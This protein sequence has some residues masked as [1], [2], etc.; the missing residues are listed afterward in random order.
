[1]QLNYSSTPMSA[2]TETFAGQMR[3]ADVAPVSTT[4]SAGVIYGEIKRHKRGV[5]VAAVALVILVVAA[6]FVWNK[7]INRPVAEP[8]RVMSITRLT[9]GGRIGEATIKGYASISPDGRYV[10]FKT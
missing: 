10:V 1:S 6:V 5:I 9:T 4:S 7:F 8:F 2:V 3:T